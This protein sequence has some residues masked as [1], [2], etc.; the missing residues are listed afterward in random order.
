MTPF[1]RDVPPSPPSPSPPPPTPPPLPL[2]EPFLAVD[3]HLVFLAAKYANWD[4]GGL[5]MVNS[6]AL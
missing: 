2:V 3:E 1:R 5:F 6:V 4:G